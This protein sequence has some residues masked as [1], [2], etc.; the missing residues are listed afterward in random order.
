[1]AAEDNDSKAPR[2]ENTG[3]CEGGCRINI[4]ITSS[5]VNIYNCTSPPPHDEP[6]PPPP[7]EDDH[8]CPPT[9]TGACVPA[10]LGAKPK[11]SRQ[12]KLEK[13]LANTRVPS[14]LAA[15][16]FHM[17]RRFLANKSPANELEQRVFARLNALS[18]D[19]K[20]VC[21]CARDSF[22]SLSSNDRDRLF[23]DLQ[24][25]ID[26]PLTVDELTQAFAQ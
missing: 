22:D 14:S 3:D 16:F 6:C 23:V 13:L 7:P 20:R 1:M 10:S 15:S 19:L 2:S 11:Q 25:G 9:A 8:T 4:Q 24:H 21:A 12:R 17:S 26:Q 18:P 5:D